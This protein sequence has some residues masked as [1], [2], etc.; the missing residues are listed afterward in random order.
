MNVEKLE[1]SAKEM[2]REKLERAQAVKALEMFS[3]SAL[4]KLW[5]IH[6]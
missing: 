3:S 6:E 5:K 1:M 2:E 4:G